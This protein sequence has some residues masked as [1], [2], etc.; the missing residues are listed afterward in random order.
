MDQATFTHQRFLWNQRERGQD[1]DLDRHLDVCAG[2]YC[3]ETVA[4][5]YEPLHNSQ[6]LSVTHFEKTR[7]LQAFSSIDYKES[8]MV[9]CNQLSLFD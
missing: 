4:S 8:K 7:F 3:Q 6:I 9:T 2:R 5:G 1:P